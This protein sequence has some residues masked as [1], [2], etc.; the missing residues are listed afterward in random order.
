[1]YWSFGKS[2]VSILSAVGIYV[3]L[4][5]NYFYLLGHVHFVLICDSL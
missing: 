2:S 4:F 5:S 3:E 1:M